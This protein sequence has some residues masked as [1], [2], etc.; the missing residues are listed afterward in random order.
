MVKWNF[1]V[2]FGLREKECSSHMI[3][4][5]LLTVPHLQKFLV[6]KNGKVVRRYSSMAKPEDIGKDVEEFLKA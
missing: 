1:E 6:D 2:Y 5:Q 4:V 3:F